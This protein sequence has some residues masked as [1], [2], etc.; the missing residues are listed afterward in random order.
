MMRGLVLI[1]IALFMVSCGSQG[2]YVTFKAPTFR[3]LANCEPW[4]QKMFTD[5]CEWKYYDSDVKTKLVFNKKGRKNLYQ[6]HIM[7]L[8]FPP[9]TTLTYNQ[10]GS[11]MNKNRG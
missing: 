2:N 10:Y 7:I 1:V 5:F 3:Q 11:W 4:Q 8:G 6:Q 9:D